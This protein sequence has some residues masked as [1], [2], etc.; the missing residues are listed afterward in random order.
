MIKT[1]PPLLGAQFS[2]LVRGTK[3]PHA[4]WHKKKK[5]REKRKTEKKGRSL[6]LVAPDRSASSGLSHMIDTRKEWYANQKAYFMT[7]DER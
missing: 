6:A 7:D 2:P 1:E 4:L 5:K 3:I